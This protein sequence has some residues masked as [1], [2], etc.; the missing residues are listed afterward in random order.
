MQQVIT[1]ANVGP[2]FCHYMALLGHNELTLELCLFC[3]NALR[4][5]HNVCHSTDIFNA[6]LKWNFCIN[7]IKISL[8]CCS[9][10]FNWQKVSTGS[11]NGLESTN[12]MPLPEAMKTRS[13]TPLGHNELTHSIV[14]LEV[15]MQWIF[16]HMNLQC[17]AT[18]KAMMFNGT[19]WI[20]E[21]FL[22]GVSFSVTS[23]FTSSTL[24]SV[25]LTSWLTLS[26]GMDALS[27]ASSG[28]TYNLEI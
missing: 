25:T 26:S 2:V 13:L 15:F 23:T 16:S 9:L 12:S 14:K 22:S 17:I 19:K 8:N 18:R 7:S 6:L 24:A 21:P 5:E 20:R 27:E 4:L 11:T 3:I 1:W 28:K 10:Q